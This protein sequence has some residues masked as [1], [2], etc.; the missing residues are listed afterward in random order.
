M[1][2]TSAS[3]YRVEINGFPV[4]KASKATLGA[5]KH[6][7]HKHQSGNV[8]LPEQ[9][10]SN[11][12]IEESTFEHA[13]GDGNIDRL[14][15]A[16]IDNVANGLDG[17]RNARVVIFDKTGRIPLRTWELIGCLPTSI[18]PED[19]SGGSN[20]TSLFSFSLQPDDMRLI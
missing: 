20:D 6:T 13:T 4:I 19:H 18:K 1:A 17:P 8:R 5:K 10:P 14:F 2:I 11:L 9:G 15:D 16:W 7:P 3:K 12:E